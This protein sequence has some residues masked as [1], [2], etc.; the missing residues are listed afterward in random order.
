MLKNLLLAVVVL[1]AAVVGAD[2]A[3]LLGIRRIEMN[4]I[5]HLRVK[6]VDKNTGQTLTDVHV[7]CVRRGSEEVCSQKAQSAEGVLT[8]NFIV[9]KSAIYT[10]LLKFKKDEQVWLDDEGEVYLVFIHPNY[11][12][13][14]LQVKTAD[15][16][17]WG[18]E[19]KLV[20]LEPFGTSQS[21]DSTS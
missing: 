18:D 9:A 11:D 17:E 13:Y 20:P 6:P 1:I 12:R 21:K 2:Y 4:D 19:V 8:L 14:W 10:R 3:G 16:V 7:T 15:I 5:L